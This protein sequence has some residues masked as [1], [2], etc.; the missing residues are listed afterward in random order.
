MNFNTKI[1]LTRN[2]LLNIGGG[3]LAT[4]IIGGV[5]A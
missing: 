4:Q 2:P 5:A 1:N 3:Y